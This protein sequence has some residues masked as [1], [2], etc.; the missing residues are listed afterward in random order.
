MFNVITLR[1]TFHVSVEDS[2]AVSRKDHLFEERILKQNK[3]QRRE[4]SEK[5]RRRNYP[6]LVIK[7]RKQR[8]GERYKHRRD[9]DEQYREPGDHLRRQ[10]D[11]EIVEGVSRREYPE[12]Y[13]NRGARGEARDQ[14]GDDERDELS[15]F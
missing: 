11:Q 7:H 14:V 12:E 10:R 3:Q 13:E 8:R 9:G 6:F 1:P 2:F 15:V 4:T 5:Y